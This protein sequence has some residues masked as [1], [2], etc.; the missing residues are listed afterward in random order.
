MKKGMLLLLALIVIG[1]M[2]VSAQNGRWTTEKANDWYRSNG[3][4]NGVNYIPSDAINY[5]AMWDKTS[6][7]PE[8]IDRELA[9]AEDLGFN[10]VRV[11]L[12]HAVYADD[13]EYFLKT[14][15]Q[16]LSICAK[17]K[18]RV[19]PAFF[20]DCVFGVN[21][22][23]VIGK[24]PEPLIGWYAWAW[25]PSPGHTMVIDPRYHPALEKYVKA[26]L[27]KFRND[28][29]IFVWD[30]YNEPGTAIAQPGFPL[31]RKV[32]EWAREINPSQPVT[33]G[34]WVE[35]K[36]W[37]ERNAYFIDNSDIISYHCY[38]NKEEMSARIE[39]YKQYGRPVICTEWMNRPSKSTVRDI[40]PLLKQENVSAILWG[41][42]NGKTQTDLSWGHRP[43]KMPY[44]GEWQ[45]DLFHTD[46]TPYDK[47]ELELIK[48]LNGK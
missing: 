10:C 3:W 32:F 15:D 16:F 33:I 11:V 17:H 46:F 27:N 1:S 43:E 25:S 45:H 23:P 35:N 21:A 42:V 22:D 14:L 37:E 31:V 4:F 48:A 24:Q 47:Q 28:P 29:R 41:L 12:Q 38:G 44:T 20:D 39:K 13:P 2:S 6:F 34:I 8:L 40:M 7:N 30:L 19:M 9:L 5:T 26:V 36:D 18:I